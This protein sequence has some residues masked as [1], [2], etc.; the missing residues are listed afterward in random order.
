MMLALWLS[1]SCAVNWRGGW[2]VGPRLLGAAPP[3]F[4]F[5]AVYA[6]EWFATDVRFG[7]S[8]RAARV[9]ARGVAGGL[10]LASVFN[11][12]AVSLVTN[13][14]PPEVTRPLMRLAWPLLRGGFVPHHAGELFGWD[15]PTIFY[16][17]FACGVGAALLVALW[18][19]GERPGLLAARMLAV[20]LLFAA[21]MQPALSRPRASALRGNIDRLREFSKGWEPAGRDYVSLARERAEHEGQTQPCLWYALSEQEGALGWDEDAERDEKR[22]S[23]PH[24]ACR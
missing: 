7:F 23:V 22:A 24:S 21:G 2:T 19:S 6:L 11:L 4:A 9:F 14:V 15:S 17:F 18:P 10:C 1:M 20:V 3:F 12:G 5:G 13:T 8:G 16:G